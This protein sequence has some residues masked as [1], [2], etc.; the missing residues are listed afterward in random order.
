MLRFVC[1]SGYNESPIFLRCRTTMK[2]KEIFQVDSP[3]QAVWDFLVDPHKIG[4][5]LPAVQS[6]EI[7]DD[8]HYKAIVKQK[9]GFISATFEIQTEV[10]EK[11]APS[12]LVLSNKGKTILGAS[13]TM[14]S[15]DTITLKQASERATEIT[16]ESDLSLGGQLAIL[17]AK[18]IESKAKE[19]FSG[20]TANLKAKLANAGSQQQDLTASGEGG[21]GGSKRWV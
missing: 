7:L 8:R 20:A 12:R 3:P 11:E 10:L 19:I 1:N 6:I 21:E 5:C 13:G 9:V 2:I 17:G 16:V 4:S 18:L 15:T 14:R